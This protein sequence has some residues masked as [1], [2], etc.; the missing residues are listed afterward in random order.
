MNYKINTCVVGQ[1][2]A[3]SIL[4]E[5][6]KKNKRIN[7]KAVCVRKKVSSTGFNTFNSWKKMIN[8]Y[9]PHLVII[10]TP[11][12]IQSK[13]IKY[14][15]FKKISFFAQKPLTYNYKDSKKLCFLIE[16]SKTIKTAIDLNFLE[17]KPINL[18]KKKI[19]KN[20]PLKNSEV[21]IKWLFN[22]PKHKKNHWKNNKEM[23]GGL[24]Y[25]FGF[26]LFSI[27]ISLFGDAKVVRVKKD[28]LYDIVELE[29]KRKFNIKIFFSNNYKKKNIF[30]IKYSSFNG[31]IYE[32]LNTSKNY[33]GN[34]SI[35]KNEKK[36][37]SHYKN[38]RNLNARVIASAKILSKLIYEIG[39]KNKSNNKHYDLII[40]KKVHFIINDIYKYI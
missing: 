10:G 8:N 21:V 34:F 31:T 26:H 29:A 27:I 5:I 12:K 32:L 33:H 36:I 7:V 20:P 11:P 37:F 25:N 19:K 24:Y 40:S 17:L 9:H 3:K 18:F 39:K 14:L 16:K 38:S 22:S 35:I 4:E 13:I 15:I 28:L 2:Y 6:L 23:G 30:S 1:N